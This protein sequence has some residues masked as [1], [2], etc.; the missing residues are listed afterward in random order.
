MFYLH[1]YFYHFIISKNTKIYCYLLYLFKFY[2]TYTLLYL[3]NTSMDLGTQSYV[4]YVT[5]FFKRN[6]GRTQ[7]LPREFGINTQVTLMVKIT[8]SA[9]LCTSSPNTC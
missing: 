9:S 8:L 1:F 7:L 5:C 4:Y 2:I 3:T 6:Q